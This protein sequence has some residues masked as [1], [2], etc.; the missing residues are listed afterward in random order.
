MVAV[1]VRIPEMD[2]DVAE[3]LQAL[4]PEQAGRALHRARAHW[5]QEAQDAQLQALR[6]AHRAELEHLYEV[7]ERTQERMQCKLTAAEEAH[8]RCSAAREA[9]RG[10]ASQPLP[11]SPPTVE[12]SEQ[13]S[14]ALQEHYVRCVRDYYQTR[15]R[16]PKA[17]PDV[18][19]GL[20]Q[21]GTGS[22]E[23]RERHFREA[24]HLVKQDHYRGRKRKEMDP[25]EPT[26]AEPGDTA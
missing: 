13:A 23:E 25:P 3:W 18:E 21:G 7:L 24:V 12:A 9:E 2:R 19:R 5:I 1:Q 10:A 14:A 16:L 15:K 11:A 6:D 20:A 22:E 26:E 8:R 4:P 17:R